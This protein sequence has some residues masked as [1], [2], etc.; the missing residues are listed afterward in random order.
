[1]QIPATAKMLTGGLGYTYSLSSAPP[2]V[3]TNVM[4]FPWTAGT[5]QG[6]GGL[7]VPAPNVEGRHR[8]T[9]PPRHRR[10]RQCKA[11]H[12]TLGVKPNFHAGQRN[13]GPT[14]SFCHNPNR[15]SSG[16]SAGSKASHPRHPR[17]PQAHR[18]VHLARLAAGA[19]YG[20]IE[21]RARSTPA[22]PATSTTP[23][24]SPTRPT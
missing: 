19:G 2:L 7:S 15:T 12:G 22:P 1:M 20:E 4:G 18:A 21:F 17:R 10:Q 5:G 11:C 9:G 14:C 13:D 16:W 8:Y 6:Q 23:T 3:Q 24:T